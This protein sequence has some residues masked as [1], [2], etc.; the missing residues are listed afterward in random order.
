M[1]ISSF[2][3]ESK[4]VCLDM[5]RTA[6]INRFDQMK[7]NFKYSHVSEWMLILFVWVNPEKELPTRNICINCMEFSTVLFIKLPSWTAALLVVN[8]M[9]HYSINGIWGIGCKVIYLKSFWGGCKRHS[10]TR[11]FYS[12][13]C[14]GEP[15][16][17]ITSGD[18]PIRDLK[19]MFI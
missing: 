1:P 6:F 5:H 13:K 12:C 19:F 14:Y 16:L 2:N 15:L 18:F 17:L 8:T 11:I 7:T 3:Y 10:M 4:R 9:K